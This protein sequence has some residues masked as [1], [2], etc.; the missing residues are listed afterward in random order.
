MLIENLNRTRCNIRKYDEK[1]MQRNENPFN[2]KTLIKTIKFR[3]TTYDTRTDKHTFIN[4]YFI[5]FANIKYR[6][7]LKHLNVNQIL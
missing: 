4:I 5:L 7:T 6:K 3:Q 2:L 1:R